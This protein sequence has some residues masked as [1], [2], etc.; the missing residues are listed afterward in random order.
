V[1]GPLVRVAAG[2]YVAP[3][4]RIVGDVR[5]AAESGVFPGTILRGQA[6]HIEIG[7]QANV[8][9]NCV[10]EATPGHPVLIGARVSLGHNA[11]VYGAT[12]EAAALIAIGA[13]VRAGARVGTHAIVA[14]NATVPEGM[15]V[16][17]RTLLIGHGRILREVTEAEIERIEHGADEYARLARE[18][19][20]TM[21]GL[22]KR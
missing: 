20:S 17:P 19:L 13:T 4:A 8:Q 7:Y 18:Y 16:P 14:A 6:A 22:V 3:G 15:E 10:V 12:I 2:A 1:E 11:R 9:D 5:L 21:A